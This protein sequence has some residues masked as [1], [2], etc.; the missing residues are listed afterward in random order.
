MSYSELRYVKTEH[1]PNQFSTCIVGKKNGY[2]VTIPLVDKNSDYI[3]VM[4]LVD[5]GELTIASTNGK[6]ICFE[7]CTEKDET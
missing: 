3:K 6:Y 5:A 4:Q 7:D 2:N 1:L